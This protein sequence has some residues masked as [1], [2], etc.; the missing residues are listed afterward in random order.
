M[1]IVP[2]S[3]NLEITG[4]YGEV[5][6]D[7]GFNYIFNFL[8]RIIEGGK[9]VHVCGIERIGM[10]LRVKFLNKSG[11]TC[12]IKLYKIL[13]P[14]ILVT[15]HNSREPVRLGMK[16]YTLRVPPGY[17]EYPIQKQSEKRDDLYIFSYK[18]T[19]GSSQV[20]VA[21]CF[22]ND[23]HVADK[24]TIGFFND[25]SIDSYIDLFG[26][27][28]DFLVSH[29]RFPPPKNGTDLKQTSNERKF[30][31]NGEPMRFVLQPTQEGKGCILSYTFQVQNNIQNVYV[32]SQYYVGNFLNVVFF[33]ESGGEIYVDVQGWETYPYS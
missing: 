4:D 14:H 11:S 3:P 13:N 27:E 1:F 10:G 22:L 31:K 17:I 15:N 19:Q 18:I 25:G 8:Y 21:S 33:N 16:Y 29:D 26:V 20:F 5:D 12:T 23:I 7:D 24:F 28:E 6:I 2:H 32:S 9:R 30:I